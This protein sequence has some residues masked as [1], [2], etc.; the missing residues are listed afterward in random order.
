M[1]T[2]L[3]LNTKAL[4]IFAKFFSAG[5]CAE[6]GPNYPFLSR[7]SQPVPARAGQRASSNQNVRRQKATILWQHQHGS[8][9]ITSHGK[10]NLS[11]YHLIAALPQLL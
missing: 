6:A 4:V 2:L 5:W 10:S 7:N 9:N 3:D 11:V 1:M 8:R